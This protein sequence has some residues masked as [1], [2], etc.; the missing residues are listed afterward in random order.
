VDSSPVIAGRRV[1]IGSTDGILYVLDL[2]KGTELQRINLGSP[3]NGS[4]ALADGH[5]VIGTGD[6]VVFCLG[7]KRKE[8]ADTK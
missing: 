7:E 3:I 4:P 2:A 8:S 6:G 1:Y 5:L